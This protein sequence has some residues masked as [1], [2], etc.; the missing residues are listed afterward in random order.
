MDARRDADIEMLDIGFDSTLGFACF[1]EE[2]RLELGE[3]GR[4]FRIVPAARIPDGAGGE[5]DRDA[6]C[7]GNCDR[8]NPC[9]CK[10]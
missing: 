5:S 4:D 9:C 3:F 7:E 10:I 1:V 2:L 8:L 6:R